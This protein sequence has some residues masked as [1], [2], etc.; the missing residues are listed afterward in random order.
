MEALAIDLGLGRYVAWMA[1]G[2]AAAVAGA[3][4]LAYEHW[5]ETRSDDD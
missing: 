4:V 2:A 3:V 1:C 5:D